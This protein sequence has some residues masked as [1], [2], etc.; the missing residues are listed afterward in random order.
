MQPGGIP[1]VAR[2]ESAMRIGYTLSR[3]SCVRELRAYFANTHD[4]P[5]A[6]RR[7]RRRRRDGPGKRLPK[8]VAQMGKDGWLTLS[9]PTEFGGQAR[10]PMDGLIFNDRRPGQRAGAVPDHQQRR[11]D[12]H[13]VRHRGTEEVLSAQDRL[14]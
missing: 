9:W 6:P 3:R 13:G 1:E 8:T 4:S 11:A 5:N 12:D 7:W 14:R 10:P 2:S